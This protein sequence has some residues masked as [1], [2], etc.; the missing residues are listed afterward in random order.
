MDNMSYILFICVVGPLLSLLLFMER[1]GRTAVEFILCGIVCCLFI[2]EVNGLLLNSFNCSTYY[3]TT[4]IAP[5]TEEIIKA[6]PIFCYG[7]I[8]RLKPKEIIAASFCVGIGFAVM[9]NLIVLSQ[10]FESVNIFWAVIRGFSSGLMHGI[11]SIIAGCCVSFIHK[12]KK[13]FV[14]GSIATMNIV[15]VYHSMFNYLVQAQNT[16]INYVG[17]FLP[18]LTYTIF[19]IVLFR[20]KKL[21]ELVKR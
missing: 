10:N 1:K 8:C 9:E 13:L 2:S 16:I 7:F 12:K 5:V 19:V 18:I 15:M 14:C 4:S 3:F 17:F 20:G 11:C 21:K 6:F